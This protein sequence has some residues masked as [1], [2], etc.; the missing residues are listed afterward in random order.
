MACGNERSLA[1]LGYDVNVG[2]NTTAHTII[3]LRNTGV[4]FKTDDQGY[5]DYLKLISTVQADADALNKQLDTFAVLDSTN[6]DAVLTAIDKVATD[7]VLA[8]ALG[9]TKLPPQVIAAITIGQAALN[10]GRIV[11][12]A[13]KNKPAAKPVALAKLKYTPVPVAVN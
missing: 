11:V 2:I 6:A 12:A 13:Y 5:R 4:I 9:A 8:K 3:D 10:G 1:K 7:L